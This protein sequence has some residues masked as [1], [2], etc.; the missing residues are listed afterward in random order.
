M[1]QDLQNAIDKS[2]KAADES[3]TECDLVQTLERETG[4][5][6]SK[7]TKLENKLKRASPRSNSNVANLGTQNVVMVRNV[8][9]RFSKNLVP[10]ELPSKM[11]QKYSGWSNSRL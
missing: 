3:R 5:L 11:I 6:Q 1:S 10:K 7:I 9:I 2:R 4:K 8:G